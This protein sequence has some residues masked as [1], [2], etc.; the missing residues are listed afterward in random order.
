MTEVKV[1]LKKSLIGA[2]WKSK[3]AARCLGLRKLNSSRVFKNTSAF[4]GQINRLRHWVEVVEEIASQKPSSSKS[5]SAKKSKSLQ[6][7]KPASKNT[8]S[9]GTPVAAK[10]PASQNKKTSPKKKPVQRKKQK[11]EKL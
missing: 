3:E 5:I 8:K 6:K 4:Q 1:I 2:P 7:K 10:K 9:K 11:G